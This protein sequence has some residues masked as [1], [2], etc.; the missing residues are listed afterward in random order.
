MAAFSEKFIWPIVGIFIFGVLAGFYIDDRRRLVE[1]GG[2][3]NEHG[4]RAVGGLH[5]RREPVSG[6]GSNLWH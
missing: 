6:V 2:S 1:E 4:S 3:T 5:Y